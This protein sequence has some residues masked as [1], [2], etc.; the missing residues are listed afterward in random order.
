[1]TSWFMSCFV[2]SLP[3]EAVVR[4]W[5]TLFYEGSK[6]LF[7]IGL[8]VLKLGEQEIRA[9]KDPMEVSQV[10]QSVPRKLLDVNALVD[11]CYKRRG[12]FGGLS[13]DTIERRRRERREV[14]RK[15]KEKKDGGRRQARTMA[16]QKGGPDDASA[17]PDGNIPDVPAL[18]PKDFG[19]DDSNSLQSDTPGTPA[20]MRMPFGGGRD[21]E[22]SSIAHFYNTENEDEDTDQPATPTS[23]LTS[24]TPKMGEADPEPSARN[25]GKRRY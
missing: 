10:V 17:M 12:G 2:S 23:P 7:R 13:Q 18:L 1:L 14:F 8:A 6:A 16:S 9:I 22:V 20:S 21:S 11:I 4:V 15:E 24:M 5:D 19:N 3:I 25:V